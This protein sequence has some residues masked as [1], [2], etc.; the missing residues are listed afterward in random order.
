MDI[1]SISYKRIN[2]RINITQPPHNLNFYTEIKDL[3]QRISLEKS[4]GSNGERKYWVRIKNVDL[5]EAKSYQISAIEYCD[6][7]DFVREYDD[8][9]MYSFEE[10]EA[11]ENTKKANEIIVRRKITNSIMELEI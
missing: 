10:K 4:N 3:P 8:N 5:S 6:L 9:Y 11:M 7:I 1:I 2:I